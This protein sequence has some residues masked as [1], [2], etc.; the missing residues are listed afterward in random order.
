MSTQTILV[1]DDSTTIRKMVDSHLTQEGYRVVLA[2][3]AEKGLELAPELLPDLILLDHQLPGTTGI[4]VC[5]K[6]IS[7]PKCAHLPFV[8]SSTLRKQA[9]IEYMDVP[10]V[11]D[12]LPKPFKAELLK[13]TIANALEV[14]AMIVSSQTD[15]TAVP[16][17]V[18][19]VADCSLSGDF[20]WV[21]L[22]ELL[23]FLNNGNKKGL[24]EV[25]LDHDRVWFFLDEGRIQTVVSASMSPDKVAEHLPDSLVPLAPLLKFTMSSGFT[26]QLDGFVELLDRKVLDPRML[27]TLLRFQAAFLTMNCMYETVKSFNFYA[28][29]DLPPLFKRTP[30][31]ISLAGL[32]IEA[33][34]SKQYQPEEIHQS[35]HSGWI[36]KGLRGQNLDRS[37]LSAKHLQILSVL[38][39][40]P[41]STQVLADKIDLSENEV[42]RVLEGLAL[43]DWVTKKKIESGLVIVALESD[44]VGSKLIHDTF[45]AGSNDWNGKVV[46]D[47]FGLQLLLNR[48]T[49]DLLAIELT[50]QELKLPKALDSKLEPFIEK[51][52]LGLILPEQ[53]AEEELSSELALLPILRRP[54]D[55]QNVIEFFEALKESAEIHFEEFVSTN[56]VSP[57]L[58]T[59]GQE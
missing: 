58:Q 24:L 45:A 26:S 29:R 39:S 36:R 31:Q 48:N 22:R 28:D 15:G 50:G 53:S 46:R 11:V 19:D 9:Y 1:I 30:L 59:T 7:D 40:E 16:E 34:L 6:I 27:R 5:R 47:E 55:Q 41:I 20:S 21:S 17:V 37:G 44:P 4:E 12:S 18:D 38:G 14:G 57:E 23:D 10:N 13:S 52:C 2:P 42:Q 43:A 8:V 25:E 3:T 33:A 56:S 49:T 35:E 51:G 32:L 54:Y